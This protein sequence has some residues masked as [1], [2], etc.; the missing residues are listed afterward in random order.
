M[1]TPGRRH[2]ARAMEIASRSGSAQRGL[3]ALVTSVLLISLAAAGQ[4]SRYGKAPE[5]PSQDPR[6]WIGPPQSLK[7]LEGRVVILDVWTFG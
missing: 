5:F 6:H 3:G 4:T 2:S 7:G 1:T